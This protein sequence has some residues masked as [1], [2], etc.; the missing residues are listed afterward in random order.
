MIV[1][2]VRAPMPRS[3]RK[4]R[5]QECGAAAQSADERNERYALRSRRDGEK[6]LRR[7][8]GWGEYGSQDSLLSHGFFT[9]RSTARAATEVNKFATDCMTVARAR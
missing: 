4:A 9:R 2:D 8:E 3:V 1:P 5:K 7:H 6:R